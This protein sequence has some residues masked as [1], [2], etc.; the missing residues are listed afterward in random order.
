M[1]W[2]EEQDWERRE[3]DELEQ[4]LRPGWL[5]CG[6]L[7]HG[8]RATTKDKSPIMFQSSRELQS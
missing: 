8:G 1:G 5:V 3:G 7:L 4:A 6:I 2:E